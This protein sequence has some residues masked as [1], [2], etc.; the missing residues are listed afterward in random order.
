MRG[1][2]GVPLKNAKLDDGAD[3]QD[4][5][6]VVDYI[7]DTHCQEDGSRK[8]YGFGM[9]LGA[10]RLANFCAE[11]GSNCKLTACFSLCAHFEARKAF[12]F[13]KTNKLGIYDFALCM[14]QIAV[15]RGLCLQYD[16]LVKNEE[17]KIVPDLMKA[18]L[19]T[20]DYPVMCMKLGGYQTMESY[21]EKFDVTHQMKNIKTP[22]FFMQAKDDPFFGPSVIPDKCH[23]D[24]VLLGTTDYGGHICWIEGTFLPTGQWWT[25]PAFDFLEAIGKQNEKNK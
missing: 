9:S 4:I 22:I 15:S 20:R 1:Y 3:I 16:N 17:D 18:R 2:S 10:G 21:L 5:V 23:S 6:E 13:L 14:R 8:L 11:M 12:T 25:K 19:I 24:N 7:H